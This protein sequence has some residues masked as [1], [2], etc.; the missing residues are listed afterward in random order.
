MRVNL[1]SFG[2]PPTLWCD[3]MVWLCF[4]PVPGG[5]HDSMTS[6]YSVPFVATCQS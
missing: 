5:G 4:C 2:S 3:L 1:R 6:G